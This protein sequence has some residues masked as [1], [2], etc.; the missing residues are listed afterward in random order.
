[1]QAVLSLLWAHISEGTFS[2]NGGHMYIAF[3]LIT[4]FRE[5]LAKILTIINFQLLN[6][7]NKS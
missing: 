4:F 5:H 7:Y 3:Y 2:P 6:L 1:M